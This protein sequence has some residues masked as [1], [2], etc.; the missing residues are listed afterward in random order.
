M[1][2]GE[3]LVWGVFLRVGTAVAFWR[4]LVTNG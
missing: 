2:L 3:A 4:T 1:I